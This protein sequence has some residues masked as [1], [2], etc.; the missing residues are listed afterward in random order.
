MKYTHKNKGTC[1]SKVQFDIESGKVHNVTFTNGCD[2]NLQA[3]AVLIEGMDA[4]EAVRRLKGLRC[5][6]KSTSCPDQLSQAIEEA[7]ETL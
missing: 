3:I 1:S 2:G 4:V 7:L 5:G 6:L